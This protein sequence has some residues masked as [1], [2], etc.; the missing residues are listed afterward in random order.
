MDRA[1][2]I[3]RLLF[4]DRTGTLVE[5]FFNPQNSFEGDLLHTL[6]YNDL[7]R[8]TIGDLFAVTMLDVRVSPLGVRRLIY[9][10]T[11]SGEISKLLRSIPSDVDLWN[12]PELVVPE[13]NAYA[14]WQLLQRRG[15]A[16]GPVTSAK[17]LCRKRPRLVPIFDRVVERIIGKSSTSTWEFFATYLQDDSRLLRLDQLRPSSLIESFTPLRLLDI[18]LWMWGS[19]GRAAKR[20]R[21]RAGAPEAGWEELLVGG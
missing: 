6:P 21:G 13:S 18:T 12:A 19:Q 10:P 1:G 8:I 9:D 17:L 20:T 4:D 7:K 5:E 3:D 2:L 15:T 14:L 16:I 11:I